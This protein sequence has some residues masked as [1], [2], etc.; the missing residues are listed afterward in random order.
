LM[1]LVIGCRS[2]LVEFLWLLMYTIISSSNSDTL[3]SSLA[4]FP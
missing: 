3:T 4:I 1:K 2:S